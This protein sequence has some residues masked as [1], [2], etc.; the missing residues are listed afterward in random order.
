MLSRDDFDYVLSVHQFDF[1]SM[2]EIFSDPSINLLNANIAQKV[3]KSKAA[4]SKLSK[5]HDVFFHLRLHYGPE[6]RIHEPHV[7]SLLPLSGPSGTRSSLW[8][9]LSNCMGPLLIAFIILPSSLGTY[10]FG[11]I[12]V[13]FHTDAVF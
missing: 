10:Q 8:N 13:G 11:I 3:R 2:V 6:C 1:D 4:G 9:N 12:F 5:I 7:L